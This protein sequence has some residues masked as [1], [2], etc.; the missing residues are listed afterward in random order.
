MLPAEGADSCTSGLLIR[1]KRSPPAAG[2]GVAAGPPKSVEAPENAD[3]A[4]FSGFS[5]VSSSSSSPGCA[6]CEAVNGVNDFVACSF[7]Q[8]LKTLSPPDAAAEL[9]FVVAAGGEPLL[10]AAQPSILGASAGLSAVDW[11]AAEVN[12]LLEAGFGVSAGLLNSDWFPAD[13]NRL[14]LAGL[15]VSAGL[16]PNK[17]ELA[18]GVKKRLL[19]AGLGVSAG[20]LKIDWLPAEENRLLESGFG[21]SAGLLN[22]DGVVAGWNKLSGAF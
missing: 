13:E 8:P 12:K 11:L 2:F 4:G 14:L 17:V 7:C 9:P 5:V 22:N 6:A 10:K 16:L 20:L 1:L 15:G 3:C 21:V 18:L 19:D